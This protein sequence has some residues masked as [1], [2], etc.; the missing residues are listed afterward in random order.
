MKKLVANVLI[1]AMS[2]SIL[3]GCGDSGNKVSP[4]S[5]AENDTAL[6]FQIESNDMQEVSEPIKSHIVSG[7]NVTYESDEISITISELIRTSVNTTVTLTVSNKT[8]QTLGIYPDSWYINGYRVKP[9]TFGYMTIEPNAEEVTSDVILPIEK[10]E[11]LGIS[12][13]G[14]VTLLCELRDASEDMLGDNVI[15][16]TVIGYQTADYSS[17]DTEMDLELSE[18]GTWEKVTLYAAVVPDGFSWCNTTI[19]FV[20]KNE[21]T[22]SVYLQL[23]DE[24]DDVSLRS[25]NG[26]VGA[27]ENYLFSF[28]GTDAIS[29]GDSIN[30]YMDIMDA[31]DQQTTLADQQVFSWTVQ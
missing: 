29:V 25:C 17:M 10:L 11:K 8:E 30:I 1:M 24:T 16:T 7:E 15:D 13:V 23:K 9:D 3:A 22:Q 4:N 14:E 31:K 2:V 18:V 27:N 19:V 5:G 28:W 12:N 26:I 20:A 6:D 21:G